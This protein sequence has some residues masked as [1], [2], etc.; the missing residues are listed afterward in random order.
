MSDET[1]ALAEALKL[2]TFEVA[3]MRLLKRLTVV[4]SDD[5]IEH[6]FYPVF[7]PDGH[8]AE[9]IAWLSAPDTPPL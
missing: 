6:V 2:P 1:F 4:L 9:V 3:G 7:P 8:A 5:R